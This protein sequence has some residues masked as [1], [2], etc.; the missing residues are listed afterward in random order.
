MNLFF[1]PTQHLMKSA[2]PK[3]QWKFGLQTLSHL[4]PAFTNPPLGGSG[5]KKNSKH[6]T[7]HFEMNLPENNCLFVIKLIWGNIYIHLVCV[8]GH[9]YNPNINSI[10][11]LVSALISSPLLPG[12]NTSLFSCWKLHYVYQPVANFVCLLFCC[13]AGS[14]QRVYI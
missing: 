14:A 11:T 10:F 5:K 7:L 2:S 9:A 8:S 1:H 6:S 4:K 13:W 3:P 12:G